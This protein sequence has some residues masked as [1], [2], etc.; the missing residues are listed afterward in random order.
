MFTVFFKCWLCIC[1]LFLNIPWKAVKCKSE[2]G[3]NFQSTRIFFTINFVPPIKII[4]LGWGKNLLTWRK[5]LQVNYVVI[6]NTAAITLW[7]YGLPLFAKNF[8][9]TRHNLH[10]AVH[11]CLPT[12]KKINYCRLSFFS[13]ANIHILFYVEKNSLVVAKH[14]KNIYKFF[15]L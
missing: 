1:L 6:N 12:N 10:W 3:N 15:H 7:L 13:R 4:L 5:G 9:W 2:H 11:N 14:R 8:A